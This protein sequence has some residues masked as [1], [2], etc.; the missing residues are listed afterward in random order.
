VA[1]VSRTVLTRDQVLAYRADV[2]ELGAPAGQVA[3]SGVLGVGVQDNPPGRSA[4][5]ALALRGRPASDESTLLIHSVRAAMHLH[6]RDD[7][8]RYAA[9]LRYEDPGELSQHSFGGPFAQELAAGG[10]TFADAV[11]GVASAMRTVMADGTERTKGEL[12]TAVTPLV[13]PRLTPWCAGC[14]VHHVHDALFRYGTL[15][16]GLT[17]EVESPTM[18]RFVRNGQP[19]GRVSTLRS[20]REIARRYL[21]L[22][23]PVRP[24]TLAAW[25]GLSPG[26]GR[27][28]WDLVA[29]KLAPVTVDGRT[30]WVH[31]ADVPDLASPPEPPELRLL[32]PY[33]PVTQ[34]ADRE[35]LVPD[36]AHRREVWRAAANPG[37]LLIR[38]DIAGIWRQST[39]N[40]LLIITVTPFSPLTATQ[41]RAAADDARTIAVHAGAADTELRVA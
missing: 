30:G 2:H 26:G 32:A 14:G 24:A 18:F 23:G 17:V 8:G 27:R 31:D 19:L 16:A 6:H 41:R 36:P 9:A 35:L 5:L 12:S 37:V 10:F 38:G 11:D 15:Q 29:G 33:D 21:R 28:W 20:R 40:R 39:S 34:L 22:A 4:R 25:L 3:G 1:P 7:L 13:D